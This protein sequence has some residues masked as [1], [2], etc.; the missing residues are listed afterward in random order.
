MT[1]LFAESAPDAEGFH[2]LYIGAAV[3]TREGRVQEGVRRLFPSPLHRGG[4]DDLP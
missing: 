4:G 3:M 2:P 1:T